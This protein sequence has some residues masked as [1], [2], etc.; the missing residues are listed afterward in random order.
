[1][2]MPQRAVPDF[3]SRLHGFAVQHAAC[4][5]ASHAAGIRLAVMLNL[6]HFHMK[7]KFTRFFKSLNTRF[8]CAGVNVI[9]PQNNM[10]ERR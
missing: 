8:S 5:L 2:Q 7:T 4:F 6:N 9:M 3:R 10:L 1:M